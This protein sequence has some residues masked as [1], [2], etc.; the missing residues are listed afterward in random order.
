MSSHITHISWG[1]GHRR[2]SPRAEVS[3]ETLELLQPWL[4][5]AVASGRIEPLPVPALS[6]FGAQ[7]IKEVGFVLVVTIYG[8]SGAY[9]DG[10]PHTGEFVP[11]ATMGVAQR[12][13]EAGELWA[14]LTTLFGKAPIAS[15][16]PVPWC[17]VALHETHLA[18][19]LS[20]VAWLGDLE[21]CIAWTWIARN[22]APGGADG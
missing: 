19:H 15:A 11:L 14:D 3:D 18:A 17:A 5:K 21:R 2:R 13:R 6:H 16:P 10:E 20:A 22:T 4:T 7:V 9:R 12:S 1:T 8:P